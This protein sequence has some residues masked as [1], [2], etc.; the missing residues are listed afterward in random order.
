MKTPIHDA[1]VRQ[2]DVL[3]AS[4]QVLVDIQRP[5]SA[6]PSDWGFDEQ[7]F[8]LATSLDK[9]FVDPGSERAKAVDALRAR[10]KR[11]DPDGMSAYFAEVDDGIRRYLDSRPDW[12]EHPEGCAWSRLELAMAQERHAMHHV[13]YLRAWLKQRGCEAPAWK[14]LGKA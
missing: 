13:G 8:H 4:V 7:L 6:D 11:L 3:L 14:G 10:R 1:I 2:T 5:D 9:W 12:E